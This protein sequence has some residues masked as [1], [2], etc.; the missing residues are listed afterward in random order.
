MSKKLADGQMGWVSKPLLCLTHIHIPCSR[1]LLGEASKGVLGL[2]PSCLHFQGQYP[3]APKAFS[4]D[5]VCAGPKE[6]NRTG[7]SFADT[8]NLNVNNCVNIYM[9]MKLTDYHSGPS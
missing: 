3:E 7:S 1:R 4:G 9:K 5:P 6:G 8:A 2:Q